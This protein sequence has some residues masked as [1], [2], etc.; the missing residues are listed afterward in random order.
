MK[1]VSVKLAFLPFRKYLILRSLIRRNKEFQKIK[2][3]LLTNLGNPFL[4]F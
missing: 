1:N 2:K 4:G 3:L